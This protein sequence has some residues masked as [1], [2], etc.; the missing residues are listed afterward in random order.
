VSLL[1]VDYTILDDKFLDIISATLFF[2]YTDLHGWTGIL[3]RALSTHISP[4]GPNINP[5]IAR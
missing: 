5:Q 2:A 4:A 3:A 1:A